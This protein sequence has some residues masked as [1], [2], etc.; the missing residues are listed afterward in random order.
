MKKKAIIIGVVIFLVL[1]IGV[2]SYFIFFNKDD[3]KTNNKDEKITITF[4]SDG[5][6]KVEKITSLTALIA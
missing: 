1:A 2:G 5:G 3:N 4:D 6:T